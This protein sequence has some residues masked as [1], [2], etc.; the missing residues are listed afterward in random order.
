MTLIDGQTNEAIGEI[1]LDY[2]PCKIAVDAPRGRAYVANSLVSTVAVVDLD[3]QEVVDTI[4]VERAPVG[5]GLGRQGDRIYA[6]N[7]GTGR[8]SVI[9]RQ[10][11]REWA[12][13]PVGKAPGDLAVDQAS[14]TVYVSDAGTSTDSVFQDRLDGKPAELPADWRHPLIGQPLPPFSLPD[15]VDGRPRTSEEWRG[16]K[17]ILNFF[18]SW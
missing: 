13:V 4:A 17:Y 9:D 10:S 14:G 15:M 7:R 12:R 5:M 1:K 3:R 2:A 18:A 6:A 16:K 8:V 11:G